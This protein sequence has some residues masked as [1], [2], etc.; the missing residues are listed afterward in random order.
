MHDGMGKKDL[1]NLG[2]TESFLLVMIHIHIRGK[3]SYFL[4]FNPFK[5][6]FT[7]EKVIGRVSS[8]NL[9]QDC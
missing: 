5:F 1:H 3:Y 6:C 7:Q 9:G 2:S 8:K 4:I